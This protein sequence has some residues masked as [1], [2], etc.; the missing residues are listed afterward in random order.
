M[1]IRA[2]VEWAWFPEDPMTLEEVRRSIEG[3]GCSPECETKTLRVV[4]I[5]EA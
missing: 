5:E 4:S 2:V 3:D 1:M